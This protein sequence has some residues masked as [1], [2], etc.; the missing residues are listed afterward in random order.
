[1]G[2]RDA[3]MVS[4]FDLLGHN[5]TLQIHWLKRVI[6]FFLDLVTVFAPLWSFLFFENIRAPWVYGVGGCVALYAYSTFS[7][8]VTRTRVGEYIVCLEI[9]SLRGPMRLSEPAVR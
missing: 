9:R 1:M 4:G 7:Q 5:R 2:T 3:L 8:A 6:A